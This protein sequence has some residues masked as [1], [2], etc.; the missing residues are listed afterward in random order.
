MNELTIY[1]ELRGGGVVVQSVATLG[2]R[3]IEAR[4][5]FMTNCKKQQ[6]IPTRLSKSL[7]IN[8]KADEN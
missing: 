2:N 7:T 6:K 5:I 3:K 1:R 4:N 8:L